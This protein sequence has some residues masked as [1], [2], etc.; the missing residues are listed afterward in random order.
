MRCISNEYD[1]LNIFACNY[2]N[3]ISRG[4][5]PQAR[6]IPLQPRSYTHTHLHHRLVPVV[7]CDPKAAAAGFVREEEQ[8]AAALLDEQ[9]W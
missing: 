2:T 3:H 6:D 8:V 7:G 1:T 4:S 9:L 5:T